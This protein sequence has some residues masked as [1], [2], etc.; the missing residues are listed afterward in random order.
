MAEKTCEEILALTKACLNAL[1]D[2]FSSRVVPEIKRLLKEVNDDNL[3]MIAAKLNVACDYKPNTDDVKNLAQKASNIFTAAVGGNLN[4]SLR[5]CANLTQLFLDWARG[6]LENELSPNGSATRLCNN[7]ADQGGFFGEADCAAADAGCVSE[8]TNWTVPNDC[9]K[10]TYTLSPNFEAQEDP[11]LTVK[12]KKIFLKPDKETII[13][14]ICDSLYDDLFIVLEGQDPEGNVITPTCRGT[15]KAGFR[16]SFGPKKLY[17]GEVTEY[18]NVQEQTKIIQALIPKFIKAYIQLIDDFIAIV[19]TEVTTAKTNAGKWLTNLK[20]GINNLA[21]AIEKK[22]NSTM[23]QYIVDIV[24]RRYAGYMKG[25]PPPSIC[26]LLHE[27]TISDK[28]PWW[29]KLDAANKCVDTIMDASMEACLVKTT[30]YFTIE[31][32]ATRGI[33]VNI[34]TLP[35]LNPV[36]KARLAQRIVVRPT[37]GKQCENITNILSVEIV[38]GKVAVTYTFRPSMAW[39]RGKMVENKGTC[40]NGDIAAFME[41]L[42]TILNNTRTPRCGQSPLEYLVVDSQD[43]GRPIKRIGDPSPETARRANAVCLYTWPNESDQNFGGTTNGPVGEGC[44]KYAMPTNCL[45]YPSIFNQEERFGFSEFFLVL[46]V[47]LP[48]LRIKNQQEDAEAIWNRIKAQIKQF[49]SVRLNVANFAACA[50][51]GITE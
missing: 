26:Y 14:A 45:Q 16:T 21:T 30:E 39:D 50:E 3:G 4:R 7:I 20:T 5:G 42:V 34:N 47:I 19:D 12:V 43:L 49:A 13:K 9:M 41:D 18:K 31:E 48:N 29:K 46:S 37:D 24:Q 2:E 1:R 25:N 36:I 44:E 11:G 32:L 28:S 17:F 33:D 38:D 51:A 22:Q 15:I 40:S 35:T 6:L 23:Q 8:L 27:R 10:D